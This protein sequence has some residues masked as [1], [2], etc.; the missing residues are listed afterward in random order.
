[1]LIL[2]SCEERDPPARTSNT[3]QGSFMEH[4]PRKERERQRR[5]R[6]FLTTAEEV[7]ARKGFYSTTIQEISEKSEFAV[8]SIYHMFRNKDEI[9]LALLEMRM[10][11]YLSLLEESIK[12]YSDPVEKIRR[13]IET[14][15]RFFSEH[16][17][18]LRLFLDTTLGSDE[19]LRTNGVEQLVGRYEDYL[20]L[21]AGIFE[22]GIKGKVF[23]GNDPIGMALAMEGMVRSFITYMIRH[24][25]DGTPL[26]EFSTIREILLQGIL[27]TNKNRKK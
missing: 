14:K 3:P 25:E 22:E 16:K 2:V 18:F 21:L 8:G 26:P 1:M 9:Y 4:L 15:F 20:G 10:E 23:S 12:D 19:N 24:E 13:L 6:E 7:F 5:Q 17:P 27:K 11:E